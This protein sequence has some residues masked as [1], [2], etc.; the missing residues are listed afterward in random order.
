MCYK[1]ADASLHQ[2][3]VLPP[4]YDRPGKPLNQ[5]FSWWLQLKL[6]TLKEQYLP[7]CRVEQEVLHLIAYPLIMSG[8]NHG[9]QRPLPEYVN[10]ELLLEKID[11]L[12]SPTFTISVWLYILEYC[13]LSN[14]CSIFHKFTWEGYYRT[15]LVFINKADNLGVWYND[16]DSLLAVGGSE[17]CPSFKGVIGDAVLYRR[18]LVQPHEIPR[19]S[20]KHP[21]YL[22]KFASS[23]NKCES[24]RGWF[25]HEIETIKKRN[26]TCSNWFADVLRVA[27]AT[28]P[29][30][31]LRQCFPLVW[32]SD[33]GKQMKKFLRTYVRLGERHL[34]KYLAQTTYDNVE[35]ILRIHG[36]ILMPTVT[37]DLERASCL[38]N[39]NATFMLSMIYNNGIGRRPDQRTARMLLWRCA[40]EN[41]RLCH[42]ALA[43]KHTFGLDQI[44]ISLE[45]AYASYKNVAD[46]TRDDRLTHTDG[47]VYTEQ[48]RLTDEER[49]SAQTAEDG[50]VFRWLKYQ[51]GQGVVSAQKHLGR[52]LYW[53]TQGVRR[54]VNAAVDYYRMGA[55]AGDL[56]AMHDY[57]IVLLKGH[58]VPK[59]VTMAVSLLERAAAK[60]N[61]HSMNTLGWYAMDVEHNMTK[62]AMYFDKAYKYG[63]PDAAHNLGHMH[64]NGFHPNSKNDSY[65][66][67][68][69]KAFQYFKFGATRGQLMSSLMVA[70][71]NMRGLPNLARNTDIA[72]DWSR[73][74]A[75]QN[76]YL[77]KLL[78]MGL[79]LYKEGAWDTAMFYYM[80]AANAGIEVG[81]FNAA[82][83]SWVKMGDYFWY[84]IHNNKNTTA[85]A[86]MYAYAALA[87]DPHGLHSLAYLVEEGSPVPPSIWVSLDIPA[88]ALESKTSLV[89]ELYRRCVDSQRIDAYVACTA[90]MFKVGLVNIWRQH[91]FVIMM[92][93]LFSGITLIILSVVAITHYVYPRRRAIATCPT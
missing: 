67:L 60:G 93:G 72:V 43:N 3:V 65:W 92:L 90:S 83:L 70:L 52:L 82:H 42:L 51:A 46:K 31:S 77:G 32:M 56:N 38:G 2:P 34:I 10:K 9:L 69:T 61:V 63:D 18:T 1:E 73:Y 16:T 23:W 71:Y 86:V 80:M 53:G 79:V 8:T 76:A 25:H 55:E 20:A 30:Y 19:P 54:D 64:L 15:P 62:A 85:A 22:V 33:N 36:L 26:R 35:Y 58:G 24:Y 49:V 27:V 87:G 12:T 11:K 89:R 45:H 78:S 84:G 68:L 47:D 44:P 39:H 41:N 48:I 5:C 50:E 7:R 37:R 4:P 88:S 14:L 59:N 57:A 74:V 75:E 81:N 13:P 29:E 28:P 91:Q 66:L 17:L 6:V 40:L 21:M